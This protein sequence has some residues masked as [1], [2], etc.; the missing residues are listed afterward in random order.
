MG[1]KRFFTVVSIWL[2]FFSFSKKKLHRVTESGHKVEFYAAVTM[3]CTTHARRMFPCWDEP[4][5]K[6]EFDISIAVCNTSHRALSN[7]VRIL[8]ML[9][10]F[11]VKVQMERKNIRLL[12]NL[13]QLTREGVFPVGTSRQL[14]LSSTFCCLCPKTK[15]LFPT[16]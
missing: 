1:T 14:R 7:M 12:L 15:R 5:L 3:L 13:K 4:I 11:F 6:A 16:W 2:H 10:N 9:Y 8:F